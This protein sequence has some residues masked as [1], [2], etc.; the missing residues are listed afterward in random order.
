MLLPRST[1]WLALC[2][3]AGG[4]SASPKIDLARRTP[5]AADQ[6]IPVEDFFRHPL[7]R[8]PRL[9]PSGTQIAGL[10]LDDHDNYQLLIHDLD[11]R[12]N[13]GA[14]ALSTEDEITH[15]VWL[16]DERVAFFVGTAKR[17]GLGMYGVDLKH[18]E[19][20]YPLQ[21]YSG[22]QLFTVPRQDRSHPLVWLAH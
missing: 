12:Q 11:S 3:L 19:R 17:F 9:N 6:T 8:E 4:L 16:G 21:L 10:V 2:V 13:R 18:P 22:A 5:V 7:W 1:P 15:Y 14:G 20:A